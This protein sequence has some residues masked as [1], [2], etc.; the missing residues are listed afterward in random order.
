[1]INFFHKKKKC[2]NRLEN[3]I[4]VSTRK[5]KEKKIILKSFK[6]LRFVNN[7]K[8]DSTYFKNNSWYKLL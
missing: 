4:E 6:L 5:K 3:Y 7:Q 2:I 8:W 1:M